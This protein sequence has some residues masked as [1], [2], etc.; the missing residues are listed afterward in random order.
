[1]VDTP[2]TQRPR[3]PAARIILIALLCGAA[4]GLLQV[5]GRRLGPPVPALQEA[6][7]A[8]LLMADT[9]Y[10]LALFLKDLAAWS[11]VPGVASPT[12]W[13]ER[14]VAQFEMLA[15]RSDPDPA[16]CHR[17]AVIYAGRGYRQQARDMLMKAMAGDESG[18]DVYLALSLVYSDDPIPP[19]DAARITQLL[20]RQPTWWALT[21][22]EQ[23]AHRL[24]AARIEKIY[25]AAALG[26]LRHH[27]ALHCRPGSGRGSRLVQPLLGVRPDRDLGL[28]P[29]SRFMARH[30]R[31]CG[32]RR[33]LQCS[34]AGRA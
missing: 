30:L 20:H 11:G 23:L 15:L 26:H 29:P 5:S 16:A 24:E 33:L 4:V 32:R 22:L 28:R 14:A 7:G 25:R 34:G 12:D 17:L 18:A 31:R 6:L 21:T 1:L 9:E 13:E 27:C 19:T 10:K 8:P 2:R 3:P